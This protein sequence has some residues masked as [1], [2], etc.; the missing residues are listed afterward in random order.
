MGKSLLDVEVPAGGMEGRVQYYDAG[1]TILGSWCSELS[2]ERR[3]KI[4]CESD[5]Q[6]QVYHKR[7][8]YD[9]EHAYTSL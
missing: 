5:F 2:S 9:I 7:R 3:G 4:A 8:R 1:L 6:L